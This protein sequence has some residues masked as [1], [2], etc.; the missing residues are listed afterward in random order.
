VYGGGG[1]TPD[2]LLDLPRKL[3]A[4]ERALRGSHVFFE[5]ADDY[6]MRYD[7]IP[8]YFEEFLLHY[9]IPQQE[10]QGFRNF[11][12]E[13]GISNGDDRPL[14]TEL[15]NLLKKHKVDDASLN[16]IMERLE[17]T[18][19]NVDETLFEKS[20]EFIERGIKQEIARMIWGSEERYRVM[21][22]ADTELIT[23]LVYFD[24]A[25]ELLARRLAIGD[26]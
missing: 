12:L 21:H 13:H 8:R 11:A 26:L 7:D 4:Y 14:R 19:I 6:L 20:T 9:R 17:Y 5:F 25:A 3:N 10:I 18:G 24:D 1:I 16:V 22:T 15:E 23:A 2:I